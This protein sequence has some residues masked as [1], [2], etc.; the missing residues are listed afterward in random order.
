[1]N[2]KYNTTNHV[3]NIELTEARFGAV[4]GR[5]HPDALAQS[6]NPPERWAAYGLL[7][8]AAN[9]RTQSTAVA[10]VIREKYWTNILLWCTTRP[11]LAINASV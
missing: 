7:A 2:G 6:Q 8:S 3:H 5:Y 10:V 1:M 4:S 11:H 9:A